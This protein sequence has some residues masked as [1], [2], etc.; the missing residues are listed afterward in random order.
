MALTAKPTECV[1]IFKDRENTRSTTR[2]YLPQTGA[3]FTNA[4]ASYTQALDIANAVQL[5]SDCVLIGVTVLFSGSDGAAVGAGEVE[6]KGVFTFATNGGT[7][8]VTAVPGFKDALLD[9]N[10]RD[11]PVL[12]SSV[13]AEV[14]A[15]VNAMLNGPV[16]ISNA[17]TNAAG[18]D[19][20]R[21]IEGH[22]EHTPSLVE[23][24]GRSG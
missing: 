8:Y 1:L 15:F 5:I 13:P 19:L 21:V 11:I 16:G 3:A 7:D 24:R 14:T 18:L 23:R 12:G 6:R 9:T 4:F 2:F 17:A 10:R 20:V 22:K